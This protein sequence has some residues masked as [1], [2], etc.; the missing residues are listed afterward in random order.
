MEKQVLIYSHANKHL[1][2]KHN[3]S[4]GSQFLQLYITFNIT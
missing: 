1:I 2:K 3:F 4:I